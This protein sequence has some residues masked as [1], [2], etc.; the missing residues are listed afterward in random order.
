MTYTEDVERTI[1]EDLNSYKDARIYA[2]E[3][4]V[5]FLEAQLQ[6]AKQYAFNHLKDY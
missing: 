4:R 3:N 5:E 2:L 1:G 6:V